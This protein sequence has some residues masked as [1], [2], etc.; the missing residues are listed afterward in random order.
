MNR[1]SIIP[2]GGYTYFLEGQKVIDN[3]LEE[4]NNNAIPFHTFNVFAK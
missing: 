3:I 2:R 4:I 1:D